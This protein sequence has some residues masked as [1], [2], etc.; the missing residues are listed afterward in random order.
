MKLI[1]KKKLTTIVNKMTK[2]IESKS[3][4]LKYRAPILQ[5]IG[6]KLYMLFI[7]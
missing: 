7:K 4:K 2:A 5:T 1:E 6:L 3:N